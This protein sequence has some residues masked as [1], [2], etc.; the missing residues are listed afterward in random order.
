MGQSGSIDATL[1]PLASTTAVKPGERVKLALR[2][3]LPEGLHM[4]SDRPRD[5]Y[6]KPTVLWLDPAAVTVHELV[7]PTATDFKVEGQPEPLSVFE[8]D[9]LIGIDAEVPKTS[10][11]GS[12]TIPARLRYQAC[13]DKFAISR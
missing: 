12:L 1:T 11:S 4:Q 6:T 5:R 7:F 3:S 9:V 8:H 13:D 2:V 10:P